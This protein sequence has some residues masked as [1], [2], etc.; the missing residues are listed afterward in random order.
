MSGCRQL[1][2]LDECFLKGNFGGQML[3]A[4]AL[5]ANDC[6]YP[7]AYAI[8]EMENARSWRWFLSHLGED[9][10]II[11]SN[12][13]TFMTDRHKGLQKVVEDLYPDAEHRFCVR[14]MY[15]KFF[16]ADFKSLTLKGRVQVR[17]NG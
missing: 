5:D 11:N 3:V 17:M 15:S 6:I 13:W 2:G 12:E 10:R 8:V 4:V 9:L 16:R 1:L 14:H 7:I